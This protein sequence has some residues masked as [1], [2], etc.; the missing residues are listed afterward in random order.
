MNFL[1]TIIH[2]HK[3]IRMYESTHGVTESHGAVIKKMMEF[4]QIIEIFFPR[5]VKLLK[6]LL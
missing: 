1:I 2:F 6:H 5:L 4:I 3:T